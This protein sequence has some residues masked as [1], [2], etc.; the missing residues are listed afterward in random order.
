MPWRYARGNALL[1]VLASTI[2]SLQVGPGTLDVCMFRESEGFWIIQYRGGSWK[3][4]WLDDCRL[5]AALVLSQTSYPILGVA[6]M[7]ELDSKLQI[8]YVGAPTRNEA[9]GVIQE[10]QGAWASAPQ[11][12]PPRLAKNS[13]RA[14]F[15][16]PHCSVRGRCDATDLSLG[17]TQD[18]P[19]NWRK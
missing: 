9:G 18:W 17:E 4:W 3:P 16:C 15:T 5:L 2:Q 8:R 12:A 7:W 6:L 1:K 14:F 11:D 10:I 13:T 19:E